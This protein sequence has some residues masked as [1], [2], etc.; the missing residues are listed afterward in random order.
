MICSHNR[1]CIFALGEV[2]LTD[3]FLHF[4]EKQIIRRIKQPIL[5][6]IFNKLII[7]HS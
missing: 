1:E 6:P 5:V 4:A 3:L 2:S 7:D